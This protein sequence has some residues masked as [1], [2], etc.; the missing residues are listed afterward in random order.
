MLQLYR[1]YHDFAHLREKSKVNIVSK[2]VMNMLYKTLSVWS[3]SI[4]GPN[5]HVRPREGN[6]P[7]WAAMVEQP[8]LK[9]YK[10]VGEP[11]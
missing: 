4:F 10:S 8:P 1:C 3:I 2:H 5:C 6:T 7:N 11:D 9:V